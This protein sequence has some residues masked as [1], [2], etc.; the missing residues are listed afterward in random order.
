M[1]QRQCV[2]I[3]SRIRYLA[4]AG[5]TVSCSIQPGS[6]PLIKPR[7]FLQ[8]SQAKLRGKL[9][10]W[11]LTSAEFVTKALNMGRRDERMISRTL[12][13]GTALSALGLFAGTADAGFYSGNQLYE[14]CS[15]EPASKTYLEDTYECVAYIAGAVDAFNTTREVNKLKSC[16]PPKVT[17]SQLK[18]VTV[19]FL[20]DNQADR[21]TSASTLVFAATRKAWPCSKKK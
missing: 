10:G 20:R 21:N 16:I 5:R 6:G 13:Y 1:S 17:V 3:G 18:D 12:N 11:P 9:R 7:P 14:V 2:S 8:T 4:I 19:A 15:T